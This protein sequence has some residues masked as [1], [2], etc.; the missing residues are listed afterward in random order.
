VSFNIL[1]YL[2][3]MKSLSAYIEMLR[4]VSEMII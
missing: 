1:L 2:L 3:E 4:V